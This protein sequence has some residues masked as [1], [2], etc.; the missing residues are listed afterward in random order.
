MYLPKIA[1][2]FHSVS[3]NPQITVTQS[4]QPQLTQLQPQFMQFQ[5]QQIQ[6]QLFQQ[7][8]NNTLSFG[9]I[10]PN[11][12]Q[13]STQQQ[14]TQLSKQQESFSFISTNKLTSFEEQ[15]TSVLRKRRTMMNRHKLKKR[16]K[17]ER[18]ST[19]KSSK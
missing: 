1:P 3:F 14:F 9:L 4:F 18:F 7:R 6:S 17:R 2:R 10:K 12:N 11:L 19:R 16:R 8:M 15:F 13:F 5:P